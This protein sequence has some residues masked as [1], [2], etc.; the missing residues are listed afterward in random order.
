MTPA[1]TIMW[2]IN[3]AVNRCKWNTTVA[4]IGR[5]KHKCEHKPHSW[6]R[7]SCISLYFALCNQPETHCIIGV[8]WASLMV[9][10]AVECFNTRH[11]LFTVVYLQAWTCNFI[12]ARRRLEERRG[13]R[14]LEERGVIW[15]NPVNALSHVLLAELRSCKTHLQ[16]VQ[17]LW[18]TSQDN[19]HQV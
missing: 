14:V 11:V 3:Q 12:T 10:Y 1:N 19:Q 2:L 9:S 7:V 13:E 8:Y 5:I 6:G 4:H 15:D 16:E 18:S 17:L